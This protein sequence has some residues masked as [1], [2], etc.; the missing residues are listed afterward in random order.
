MTNENA[1]ELLRKGH[2]IVG[3]ESAED[4]YAELNHYK[5]EV[6]YNPSY[7]TTK[8]IEYTGEVINDKG[9][10]FYFP[11]Y[12]V[13]IK[14]LDIDPV[15]L[16]IDAGDYNKEMINITK[17]TSN[18]YGD[19]TAVFIRRSDLCR[20][21]FKHFISHLLDSNITFLNASNITPFE[22]DNIVN[23]Y[24]KYYAYNILMEV[25]RLIN[26]YKLDIFRRYY[27]MHSDERGD[28]M[29]IAVTE[30]DGYFRFSKVWIA[31]EF[32]VSRF[33][34]VD[35]T[36]N[37]DV[38]SENDDN[39]ITEEQ[40]QKYIAS[41]SQLLSIIKDKKI[42]KNKKDQEEILT[43]F[44]GDLTEEQIKNLAEMANNIKDAASNITFNY[45]DGNT[46]LVQPGTSK[47]TNHNGSIITG[48]YGG[49]SIVD[50]LGGCDM[51]GVKPSDI[52]PIISTTAIENRVGDP[53][54]FVVTK[55]EAEACARKLAERQNH[56]ANAPKPRIIMTEK[57]RTE[58]LNRISEEF[59]DKCKSLL[60]G[61]KADTDF[62]NL[63]LNENVYNYNFNIVEDLFDNVLSNKELKGYDLE[64]DPCI[65][66]WHKYLNALVD[67]YNISKL[68]TDKG[69]G[70]GKAYRL[71]K[72][73]VEF[74]YK[75]YELIKHIDVPFYTPDVP[76]K[77][78]FTFVLDEFELVGGIPKMTSI[79]H[80]TV[81]YIVNYCI[82]NN[83]CSQLLMEQWKNW[84]SGIV[85]NFNAEV[86]TIRHALMRDGRI[87]SEIFRNVWDSNIGKTLML[88]IDW[89]GWH[90]EN[91]EV[92]FLLKVTEDIDGY[93][94]L[95]LIDKVPDDIK[96]SFDAGRFNTADVANIAANQE[97]IKYDPKE[98]EYD[99]DD[100]LINPGDTTAVFQTSTIFQQS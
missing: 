58:I 49:K 18:H 81:H 13:S 90:D 2:K 73:Y 59:R 56:D 30:K 67:V 24:V 42:E 3:Y 12:L 35:N 17:I 62:K 33:S 37:D 20:R 91:H 54:T 38:V 88:Y 44:K 9:I 50:I 10:I 1:F 69:F 43:Q 84:L 34:P 82:M 7:T 45:N 47:N 48:R 15:A 89:L 51:T 97:K 60:T 70:S 14:G 28:N 75:N 92:E 77:H 16:V 5:E 39:T 66:H 55:H 26:T 86:L 19:D 8:N 57:M 93:R 72:R 61:R 52:E 25:V 83:K 71:I 29:Y 94:Y 46:E 76:D 31:R 96:N 4:Y 87:E 85:E 80:D 36:N 95:L 78:T 63:W 40:R 65:I 23:S 22:K 27:N 98:F 21:G 74:L 11:H 99:E 100:W 68:C 79:L 6:G 53:N 64:H 41:I 32:G